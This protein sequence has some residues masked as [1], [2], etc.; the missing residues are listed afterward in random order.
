[1]AR[2]LRLEYEG[3]IYHVTARGN[4]RGNIFLDDEDLH[5][6]LERLEAYVDGY[7]VR[8]LMFCLM[9]NHFHMVLETP[10]GNLSRF[11]HRLQTAYT[12]YFNKRH[13]QSG[14]V[15]QGRYGAKVVED[16][17]Y[18]LSLTRY[19]HLNPTYVSKVIKLPFKERIAVL[20]EY[21]WSTYL[22]YI[23]KSKRLPFV[24]YDP[25]LSMMGTVKRRCSVAYQRFVEAGVTRVDEEFIDILGQS[26][27]CIGGE[28]FTDRVKELHFELTRSRNIKED[29]SFRKIEQKIP[30]ETVL[31]LVSKELEIV[32]ES[33]FH[34]Q[35]GTYNRAIAAR[36]LCNYCGLSQREAAGILHLNTGAAVSYQQRVL[37]EAMPRDRRLRKKI[38]QIEKLLKS[39]I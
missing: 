35:R 6:F 2:P 20:R 11:M 3:A 15:L 17:E 8:L 25:I 38:E 30:V 5:H 22:G 31:V 34:R 9:S 39:A 13:N 24:D 36:M 19:V 10:F 4:A 16:N 32:Q 12:V 14:H 18:L 26:A 29:V 37:E 7:N 28:S 1:M 23:G 33:L 21:K 27:L